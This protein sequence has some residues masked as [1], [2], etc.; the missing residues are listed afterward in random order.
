[1]EYRKLISFG[2]SSYVV[3]L[4]KTWVQQNKLKRGDLVYFDENVDGLLLQPRPESP[5]E[6]KEIVITVDGKTK[7]QIQREI[8]PAYINNFKT[9]TLIGKELKNKAE[10]I[11]PIIQNLM[12][13]EIMEQT[14]EKIIARDFLNMKDLSIPNLLR[15]MD[16]IVRSM[17]TDCILIFQEDSCENISLRDKD[18]NRLSYLIYRAVNYGLKN[19]GFM[20]KQ[21]KLT[22]ND[23]LKY[24]ILVMH[25]EVIGDE[26]RRLARYMRQIKLPK[27]KQQQFVSLVTRTQECYNETMKAVYT[28]NVQIAHNISEKK[29]ALIKD[30]E[31]FYLENRNIT[32]IAYMVDRLKRMVS[33]IHKVGR[34]VY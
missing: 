21:F 11:E 25:I 29:N 4:P 13:L 7:S 16:V 32:W 8:I 34:L 2:K 14:S 24:Y 27:A 33:T 12:A 9:V 19:Q 30:C 28:N 20:S 3:T 31:E 22:A 26:T 23:L 6:E 15:K 17:I 18:V 5:E 10:E 1:M